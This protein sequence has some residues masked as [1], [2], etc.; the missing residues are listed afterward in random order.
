MTIILFLIPVIFL[1][2]AKKTFLNYLNF[3]I[4]IVITFGF[5]YILGQYMTLGEEGKFGLVFEIYKY[6]LVFMPFYISQFLC[7]C[8]CPEE[9]GL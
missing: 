8:L 5:F 2:L 3:V 4:A 7:L 1:I 9:S 6:T